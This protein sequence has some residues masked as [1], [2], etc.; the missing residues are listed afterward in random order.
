MRMGM[1][2]LRH[3]AV[4]RQLGTVQ[5]LLDF[6]GGD[7]TVGGIDVVLGEWESFSLAENDHRVDLI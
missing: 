6:D 7:D 2:M 1:A 5:R 4:G 3:V